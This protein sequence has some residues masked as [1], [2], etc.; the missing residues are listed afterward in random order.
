MNCREMKKA[1]AEFNTFPFKRI[2]FGT[3]QSEPS[4]ERQKIVKEISHH[5]NPLVKKKKKKRKVAK[6]FQVFKINA[7]SCGKK[8]QWDQQ[9]EKQME[10]SKWEKYFF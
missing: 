4:L 9:I 2:F 6:T 7:F 5:W 8:K 3:S 1:A 10:Q